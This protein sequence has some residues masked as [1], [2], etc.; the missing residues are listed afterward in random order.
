MDL[1]S[2]AVIRDCKSFE[3]RGLK[4]A[5]LHVY[6]DFSSR[7]VTWAHV[8]EA[9]VN[10]TSMEVWHFAPKRRRHCLF[11]FVSWSNG[12]WAGA[13]LQ[14]HR[15]SPALWFCMFTDAASVSK[16]PINCLLQFP[17]LNHMIANW[18][19]VSGSNSVYLIYVLIGRIAI[20]IVLALHVSS[21]ST[22]LSFP[23]GLTVSD[24]NWRPLPEMFCRQVA[25]VYL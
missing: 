18:L 24:S 16:W 4:R 3:H 23:M 25:V 9:G 11:L 6:I 1:K 12:S 7:V 21:R 5:A 15:P 20:F 2:C 22:F 19:W 17:F 8:G 10:V 13:S 14:S